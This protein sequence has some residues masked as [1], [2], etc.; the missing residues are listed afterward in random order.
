MGASLCGKCDRPPWRFFELPTIRNSHSRSNFSLLI[1]AAHE[2][3]A[4]TPADWSDVYML[5]RVASYFLNCGSPLAKKLG[6]FSKGRNG[7][8][9]SKPSKILSGVLGGYRWPSALLMP[10]TTCPTTLDRLLP[11]DCRG[12]YCQ[13]VHYG[14]LSKRQR[15]SQPILC[16]DRFSL[17]SAF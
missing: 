8:K 17:R 12:T 7:I 3:S 13:S 9:C 5:S 10:T 6:G 4:P 14:T 16:S 11:T 15:S 1:V 2:A